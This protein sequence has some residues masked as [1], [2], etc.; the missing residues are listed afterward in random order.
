MNR[1]PYIQ[2]I[3]AALIGAFSTSALGQD[4]RVFNINLSGIAVSPDASGTVQV[5]GNP[6]GPDLVILQAR[7]LPPELRITVFLT[8][9][10]LP[11][12]LPAQFIG[13]LTTDTRGRGRLVAIA[14]V[15]NAFASG[16]PVADTDQDGVVTGRG[17]SSPPEAGGTAVIHALNWFRGYLVP[18]PGEVGVTV[19]GPNENTLGGPPV[20]ISAPAL[21]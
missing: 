14:E 12:G 18:P 6:R 3:L 9:D 17:V 13:E 20:F 5:I 19:F 7:K 11:G 2:A 16:N 8:Q 4:G 1:L 15:V 21:P 10:Q